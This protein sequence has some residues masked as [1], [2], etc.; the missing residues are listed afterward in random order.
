MSVNDRLYDEL[1][2]PVVDTYYANV[3]TLD[4]LPVDNHITR[5][6]YLGALSTLELTGDRIADVLDVARPDWATM[7]DLAVAA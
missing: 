4:R 2:K 7:R 5:S 1:L 3:K 6:W